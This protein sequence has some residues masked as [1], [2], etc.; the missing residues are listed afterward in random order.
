[1][2]FRSTEGIPESELKRDEGVSLTLK[3]LQ[4][5]GEGEVSP[6]YKI[7]ASLVLV[8][9]DKDEWGI[10]ED[11]DSDLAWQPGKGEIVGTWSRTKHDRLIYISLCTSIQALQDRA[12]QTFAQYAE[13][14]RTKNT[15]KKHAA[16]VKGATK[17]VEQEQEQ[18]VTELPFEKKLEF[19]SLRA[20]LGRAK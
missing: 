16:T 20:K 15:P 9:S 13:L 10:I 3:Q 8:D 14:R 17:K 7:K 6:H 4:T 12:V 11:T 18:P 1:V 19:N 2:L 5:I